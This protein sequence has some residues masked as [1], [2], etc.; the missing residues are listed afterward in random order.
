M[1]PRPAQSGC[2]LFAEQ[3]FSLLGTDPAR[4]FAALAAAQDRQNLQPQNGTLCR[5][6]SRMRATSFLP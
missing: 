6:L 2:K 5:V 4:A 1:K 3:H